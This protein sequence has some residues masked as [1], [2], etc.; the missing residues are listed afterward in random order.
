MFGALLSTLSASDAAAQAKVLCVYDP[1]GAAGDA[2]QYAK[3]Y[4]T[5]AIAWG[6]TFEPK[7]YTSETV[8][9]ADFRNG[10]CDA[11]ILTGVRVQQFNRKTYSVEAIGA[12]PTQ[13]AHEGEGGEPHEERRLR[14][15]RHL[16]RRRGLLVPA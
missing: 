15:G 14:D 13:A 16:P 9:A 11:V 6:V 4:Q 8:A 5:A 3:D 10:K 1:S 2:Y 7:P 12:L